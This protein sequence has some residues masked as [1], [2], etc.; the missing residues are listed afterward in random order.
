M[1]LNNSYFISKD[2]FSK[3]VIQITG[4]DMIKHSYYNCRRI[5]KTLDKKG[6]DITVAPE[7]Y[8]SIAMLERQFTELKDEDEIAKFNIIFDKM[9]KF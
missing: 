3:T 7:S 1:I 8:M 9:V 4:K 2:E 5:T 6:F